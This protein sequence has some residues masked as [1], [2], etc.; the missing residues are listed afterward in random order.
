MN[1]KHWSFTSP[2]EVSTFQRTQTWSGSRQCNAPPNILLKPI[3]GSRKA[4]NCRRNALSSK[5]P[6][7]LIADC[8]YSGGDFEIQQP[9][10]NPDPNA[11]CEQHHGD[12]RRKSIITSNC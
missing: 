1:L 11:I 8:Y 12:F 6:T 5:S 3:H 10:G 2:H 7:P 4:V 9:S